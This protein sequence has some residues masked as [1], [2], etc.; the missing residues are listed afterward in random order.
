V[1]G[2]ALVHG[3]ARVHG[4]AWVSGDAQ[5]S[6]NAVATITPISLTGLTWNITISNNWL[7]IGC[8]RHTTQAWKDFTDSEI[9]EMDSEALDFWNIHKDIILGLC[10]HH[11]SKINY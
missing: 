11:Q 7:Q 3:D 6:G 4:N 1:H 2:N 10:D 8:H 9:S 5:V